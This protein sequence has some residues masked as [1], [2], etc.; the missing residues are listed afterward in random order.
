MMSSWQSR[1]L[2]A[3]DPHLAHDD[4]NLNVFRNGDPARPFKYKGDWFVVLGAGKNVTTTY[5]PMSVP[6]ELCKNPWI[7]GELRLYKAQDANLTDWRFV[8]TIFATNKTV[9]EWAARLPNADG[10]GDVRSVANMF[11][12]PDF[13]PIGDRWMFIT[14]KIFQGHRWVTGGNHHWD[15]YYIGTFDGRTFTPDK[16]EWSTGVLDYG[17]VAA[18]K[19]GGNAANDP[20]GR[21]VFFGWNMPWSRQGWKDGKQSEGPWLGRRLKETSDDP[22]PVWP[23]IEAFGSQVLPRDL[24]L[25]PDGTLKMVPAAELSSLRKPPS[26]ATHYHGAAL[27]RSVACTG[28]KGT[29]LELNF[30]I[31]AGTGAAAGAS[32]SVMASPDGRERTLIG[33]NHTHL[34]VNQMNS[35]LTPD[36]TPEQLASVT[37]FWNNAAVSNLTILYA[38]LP[39]RATHNIRVF[40]DGYNVEVFADERVAITTNVFPVLSDATC[41]G[42]D[43]TS[44]AAEVSSLDVWTLNPAPI[45]GVPYASAHKSDDK[46]ALDSSGRCSTG[47]SAGVSALRSASRATPSAST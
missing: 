5:A 37:F 18:G 12:C 46:A 45:T 21:R 43:I 42:V 11:E 28:V 20:M 38:P 41:V 22:L 31:S 47:T 7:Q 16:L 4:G 24:S 3:G 36:L 14:S 33:C 23:V 27:K 34:I 1:S 39:K 6:C 40:L 32:V 29:Q 44:A 35:T 15:E 26:A 19:T 17:Y 13:F 30:T 8:N 2:G 9:G 10:S 25:F